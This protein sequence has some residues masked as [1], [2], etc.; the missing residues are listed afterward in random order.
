VSQARF[1]LFVVVVGSLLCACDTGYKFSTSPSNQH[2]PGAGSSSPLSSPTTSGAP[3]C[4]ARQL[5]ATGA[6]RQNANDV[7]GAIGEVII[8][9]LASNACELRGV[10]S[11]HLLERTGSPIQVES[12]Q[13]VSPVLPP[14]VVQ[15]KGK[16]T[17]ELVF[18]WQNWC[19]AA[20]GA[21]E[22]QIDLGDGGGVL[23]AP[24]DTH[25][26]SYVPTC[27]RP[28]TP[29]VLRVQYAYEAAGASR[30]ATA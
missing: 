10:P 18:T 8:S 1:F 17:A 28:D 22:I 27:T 3:S 11:L 21:L 5:S 12:S 26:R 19:G 16:S 20:L 29:S 23:V 25:P 30:S 6:S 4:T 9:D 7:V 13:S 14:V 2:P 24:L 15:P